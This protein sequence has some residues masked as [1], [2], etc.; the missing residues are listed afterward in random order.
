M[1]DSL[2]NYTTKWGLTV[3]TSKTKIVVFRNG[4]KL[5]DN[6]NWKYDGCVLEI[7][8]EFNYLGVLLNYNGKFKQT[9]K[10][11][12]EQGRKAL[13]ALMRVCKKQY[14][15]IET[16]LAVFDTYV[17]S[18][19][20]Y[21]SEIWGFHKGS[22]IEKLHINF[23]KRLLGV[24]KSTPNMMVYF[25]L[26]RYPLYITRKLRIFKY[27]FKLLNTENCILKS[28]YE[29][30]L[31]FKDQ[32]VCEIKDDLN[33]LGLGYIWDAQNGNDFTFNQNGYSAIIDMS[34]GLLY[35]ELNDKILLQSYLT[36]SV[37]ISYTKEI[38][39]LRLSAHKLNI[40]SGRYVSIDR[41]KRVCTLC[42]LNDIEDEFH[43]VLVCTRYSDLRQKYLKYY[44]KN[45]PSVYKLTQLL[46]TN[47]VKDLCN[48]GKYLLAA[49]KCRSQA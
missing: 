28:C 30:M 6:E 26:G 16:Q 4:G 14:F 1:L 45:N 25:E 44:Y 2:L 21:G 35:R 18:I 17:S 31:L 33:R 20:N 46:N 23:C 48:L 34:K 49:N 15:N 39:R 13:F 43:F 47:N 32:W 37:N 41:S 22:D 27:W 3:N 38:A 11:I 5:K 19:V 7:V 36:K 29:N 9:Q 8:N 40:E 10:K 24:R 12:S 42:N